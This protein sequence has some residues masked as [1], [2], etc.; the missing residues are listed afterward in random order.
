[1]LLEALIKLKQNL[2]IDLDLA[3]SDQLLD[4]IRTRS[5]KYI[6]I[7]PDD[8]NV[9]TNLGVK[10]EVHNLNP[11]MCIGLMQSATDYLLTQVQQNEE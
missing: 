11:D 10:I 6:F 7:L 3:T 4:E 2:L 9:V 1:M 5:L 8:N